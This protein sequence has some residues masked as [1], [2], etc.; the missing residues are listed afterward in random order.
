MQTMVIE[1]DKEVFRTHNQI[2][3][4]RSLKDK[5]VYKVKQNTIVEG[6]FNK[7][8]DLLEQAAKTLRKLPLFGFADYET[9]FEWPTVWDIQ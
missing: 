4:F 5:L 2:D 3:Y 6:H 1:F 8:Q 9:D 7:N